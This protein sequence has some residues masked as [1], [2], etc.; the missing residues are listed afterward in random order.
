MLLSSPYREA[1]RRKQEE[2]SAALRKRTGNRLQR[3]GLGD[4]I[5]WLCEQCLVETDTDFAEFVETKKKLEEI[6]K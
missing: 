3:V 2:L 6:T 5:E 4:A 1:L